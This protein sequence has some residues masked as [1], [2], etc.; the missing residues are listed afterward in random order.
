MFEN[1]LS[2]IMNIGKLNEKLQNQSLN[3]QLGIGGVSNIYNLPNTNPSNNPPIQINNYT[4]RVNC[5]NQMTMPM[6]FS[7]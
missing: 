3:N 7:K 1:H 6:P 5:V 4:I 2:S